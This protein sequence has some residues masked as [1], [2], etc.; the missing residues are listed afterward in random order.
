MSTSASRRLDIIKFNL[1]L[2]HLNSH[3]EDCKR[4]QERGYN[5]FV[6]SYIHGILLSG[7]K[8]DGNEVDVTAKCYRSYRKSD[9]P[10]K[11]VMTVSNEK[12]EI[13]FSQCSCTAG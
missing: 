1:E 9:A 13:V 5:Y 6:H 7:P 12:N 8:H 3:S 4:L 10:H 2:N 11:L